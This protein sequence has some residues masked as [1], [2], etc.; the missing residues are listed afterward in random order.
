MYSV[1]NGPGLHPVTLAM[2][3]GSSDTKYE[4]N[5]VGAEAFRSALTPGLRDPQSG[6]RG[7]GY[8]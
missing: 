7:A 5:L 4:G 2:R 3:K 8:I 6:R 1:E